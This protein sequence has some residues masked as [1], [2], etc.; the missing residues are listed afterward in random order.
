[1]PPRPI[2]ASGLVLVVLVFASWARPARA[3]PFALE[4]SFAPG[5][6]PCFSREQL[7][8]ATT[9][10]LARHAGAT[11]N[12]NDAPP[13][14]A[15]TLEISAASASWR[16]AI[17]SLRRDGGERGV[18]VLSASGCEDLRDA[19]SLVL[20]LIVE[21]AAIEPASAQPAVAPVPPPSLPAPKQR[22]RTAR[23]TRE[24]ESM[25]IR[26]GVASGVG[27]GV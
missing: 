25:P 23:P 6:A 3:E 5:V 24:L 26:I 19:L 4:L 10:R 12:A 11:P 15:I 16:A 7:L 17:T 14:V 2:A 20:A 1:M 22:T 13:S 21:E 27:L 9:L 18:R 8:A